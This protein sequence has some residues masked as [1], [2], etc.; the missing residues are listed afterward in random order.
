MDVG[1]KSRLVGSERGCLARYKGWLELFPDGVFA[2]LYGVACSL[3][4]NSKSPKLSFNSLF[5]K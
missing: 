1:C 5:K 2:K 3:F 4:V